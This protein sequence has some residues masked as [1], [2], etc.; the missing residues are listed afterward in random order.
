MSNHAK[1]LRVYLVEDS[2]AMVGLLRELFGS[3]SSLE[4]VG[5]SG[6][7]GVAASEIAI[8]APDVAIV[9]IALENSNGFAVMKAL[10]AQGGSRPIVIV[11]SNFATERYRTESQRHGADYFFDKNGEI[12]EL[13]KTIMAIGKGAAKRTSVLSG[14][15]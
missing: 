3:E 11:L 2:P 1:P 9:D 5:Q 12:L 6:K 8:L 15:P 4:I 10:A 14:D 13:L 7:A